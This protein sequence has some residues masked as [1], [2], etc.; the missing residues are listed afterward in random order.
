MGIDLKTIQTPPARKEM[1]KAGTNARIKNFLNRDIKLFRHGM[2]DSKKERFYSELTILLSSGIDIKT[3]LDIIIEE[4]KKEND[5]KLFEKIRDKVLAG[6]SLSDGLQQ[7][8][9]FSNYEYFSLRIGEES[10]RMNEV[11]QELTRYY[12]IRIKQKRQLTSAL[13]YPLLVLTIAV[14]AVIFMLNFIV[15]MFAGIFKRFGG[16]L[17]ALTKL[18]ISASAFMKEHGSTIGLLM[19]ILILILF[20]IRK[21]KWF[22]KYSSLIL[23]RLPVIGSLVNKVYLARFCQSMALLTASKTPMLRSIELVRQ[24]IGFFPF[25]EALEYIREDIMHGKMLYES[26]SKYKIFNKRTV[27]LTKVA[28][29]VNQLGNIFTKLN[30]QFTEELEYQ[31]G[32]IGNLME[33]L[34]II[35]V[36][37]LVMA[38][39]ISMYLPLFQLSTSIY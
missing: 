20:Q 31:T 39:L 7:T 32:I 16:E 12:S 1:T 21:K 14:V 9:K 18:V 34:L 22:R 29:E 11:L 6:A 19:I 2:K 33:P 35:F 36:G 3:S 30:G 28:E 25:E 24:M 13:S 27:F 17:P 10:G 8:G 15:P 4:Q 37:L 23:L 38:I 26:M 5:K